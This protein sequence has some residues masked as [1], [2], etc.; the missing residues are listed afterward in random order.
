MLG[1]TIL[2]KLGCG[3]RL[4]A[5][6]ERASSQKT[7]MRIDKMLLLSLHCLTGIAITCRDLLTGLSSTPDMTLRRTAARVHGNYRSAP[8]N[9]Q[10]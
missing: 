5:A 9:R 2:W 6:R 8:E 3:S 7:M 4:V 1:V 10:V